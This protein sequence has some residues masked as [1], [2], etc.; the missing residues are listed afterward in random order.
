MPAGALARVL[1]ESEFRSW[2]RYAARRMLPGRRIEMQLAR[3]ALEIALSRGVQN[4]ALSDFLFDPV[5]GDGEDEAT[6]EEE[7]AFFD[8]KPRNRGEA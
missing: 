2:Q 4:V 3:I 6:A 8:F 5:D 7:A 1:P